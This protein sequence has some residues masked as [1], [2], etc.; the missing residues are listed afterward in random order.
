MWAALNDAQVL[1]EIAEE[2][3]FEG[4]DLLNALRDDSLAMSVR[5]QFSD[6]RTYGT[7]ALPNV[8]IEEGSR[9]RLL[10][11]GYA[12]SEMIT[13]LVRQALAQP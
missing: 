3:E 7:H 2:F 10:F 8:L 6:S 4:R 13:T 1:V 12:D 11:G 5:N 9:R